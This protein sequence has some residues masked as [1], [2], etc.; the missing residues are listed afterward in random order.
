MC[1]HRILMED[2]KPTREPQ[3]RLNPPMKDVVR[4]E[5]LKLLDVGVIYPISDSK[6]LNTAT[7]K[8]HFP[9][10]FID[11]MLERLAG[12]SHYYWS[13]P[14][15]LMCDASNYALGAVLGQRVN[16]LPHVIYYASRTL[17]DA[18][19]NY[20]TTEK[21]LL[22]VIFALEKFRS[23]LV[24][25]KVIVYSDHAALRYLLT[26]K[27]AKPRLL[28]WVLLLQ[29]FDLEIR[30]KKGC[31]NV[32]ADHLSRLIDGNH[33]NKDVLPLNESFPD[34]QLLA[35]HD[36]EP[37][38]ADLVNYLASGVL[39]DDL[40]FRERKKFLANAKHYFGTIHICSN[41]APT[42]S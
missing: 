2:A 5:I 3:R 28:R 12:H 13:L 27:D 11:Q 41:M 9:L 4:T 40:T 36:Q 26:K 33:E 29:E 8:D 10:P 24:G 42:K 39:R 32:V 6:W 22:A 37:W 31:E 38:Y 20:S 15:E 19:L 18:Q 1:M 21:E 16:K 14:F 25:S 7:R 35:I 23:Y 34:E 17:N 30:D